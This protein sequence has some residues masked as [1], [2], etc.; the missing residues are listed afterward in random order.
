M[1]TEVSAMGRWP[2]SSVTFAFLGMGTMVAILNHVGTADWDI[3]R[4]NMPI[5]TPASWSAHAL[6][7][8]LGMPSGPAALRELTRLN[9]LLTSTAV[10]ESPHVFVAGRVSGTVFCM[11]L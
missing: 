8:R 5:N 11:S 4:L 7:A 9:V 1:M 6:R 10:K 3:E 2:M